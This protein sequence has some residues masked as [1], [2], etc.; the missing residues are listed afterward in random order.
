MWNSRQTEWTLS[1]HHMNMTSVVFPRENLFSLPSKW[2]YIIKCRNMLVW[3][4][5]Q[6]ADKAKEIGG[7]MKRQVFLWGVYVMHTLQKWVDDKL[8]CPAGIKIYLRQV[9]PIGNK[10]MHSPLC[11][12]HTDLSLV[13]TRIHIS[14]ETCSR[15]TCTHTW[16]HCGLCISQVWQFL[17]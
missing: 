8:C 10:Q 17:Q 14:T 15:K 3:L 2:Y 11:H 13:L 9:T 6:I 7:V 16:R 4:G 12:S 1:C 5:Q